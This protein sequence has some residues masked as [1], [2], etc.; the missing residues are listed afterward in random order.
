M[1]ETGLT[2][3]DRTALRRACT[4]IFGDLEA[5][6]LDALVDGFEAVD[7]L[8]GE[9]LLRQGD[10]GDSLYI[11]LRGRLSVSIADPD[12]GEERV[13]GE[14]SPGDSIGEIGL[15][16]GELRSAS[17]WATRDSRLARMGRATFDA[18]AEKHPALLRGLAGVV[19]DLL[20]K[21]TATKRTQH[22]VG[23]ITVLPIV[24]GPETRAFAAKLAAALAVFGPTLPV[25]AET[26]EKHAGIADARAVRPGS[27]E[28][29][30]IGSW[31]AEEE[32]RRAFLVFQADASLT[33]WTDRCLRQ[34][35]LI[36]AVGRSEDDPHPTEAEY[37]LEAR[38]TRRRCEARRICCS[39]P[40]SD[41][42]GCSNRMPSMRSSRSGTTM[43]VRL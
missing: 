33:P 10:P 19:V 40:R 20:R 5:D 16:T 26:V 13:V 29:A 30:R 41:G 21:R 37:A 27:D 6:L 34:A 31:L 15:L 12:T 24:E 14:T 25:D 28:D 35:D 22:A 3:H 9:A 17:L 23:T 1:P 2:A 7:V 11:L 43:R 42:S 39:V 38:S 36:V 4:G 18:L 32:E 8:G